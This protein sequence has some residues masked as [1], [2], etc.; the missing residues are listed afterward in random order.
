[1]YLKEGLDQ[2]LDQ[3]GDMDGGLQE[4]SIDNGIY[5]V[6]PSTEVQMARGGRAGDHAC[7][8]SPTTGAADASRVTTESRKMKKN[9]ER[10]LEKIEQTSAP[11]SLPLF[12]TV[13]VRP[14]QAHPQVFGF[15]RVEFDRC[16]CRY[17][18]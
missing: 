3:S 8:C 18:E 6:S 14:R 13:E 1:M 11:P 10:D 17:E 2:A 15:P 4:V 16:S 12:S 5:F 7:P 9:E